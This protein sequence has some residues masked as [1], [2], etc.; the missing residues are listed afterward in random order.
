MVTK[1]LSYVK[2]HYQIA[3]VVM[4]QQRITYASVGIGTTYFAD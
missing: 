4:K 3:A 2:Y 1:N